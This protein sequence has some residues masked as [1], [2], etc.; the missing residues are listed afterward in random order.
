M[1]EAVKL[2]KKK[3]QFLESEFAKPIIDSH[4]NFVQEVNIS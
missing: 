4:K 1:E 2:I 3:I